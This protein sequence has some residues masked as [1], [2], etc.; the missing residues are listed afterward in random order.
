MDIGDWTS[1]GAGRLSLS[2]SSPRYAAEITQQGRQWQWRAEI[3]GAQAG[4]TGRD[5]AQAI[6]QVED[7]IARRIQGRA[8]SPRATAQR[9]GGDKPQGEEE[10]EGLK[11]WRVIIDPA[12]LLAFAF[13][14]R[15]RL[16]FWRLRLGPPSRAKKRGRKR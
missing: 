14:W 16:R 15:G 5:V 4:G 7:E 6:E 10:G 13:V 12:T 8:S 2:P 3:D 1:H 9:Q 11:A